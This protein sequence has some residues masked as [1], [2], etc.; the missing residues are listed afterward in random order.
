MLSDP[1]LWRTGA[2][3][4]GAW[5]TETPHG[6]YDLKNPATGELLV[7]LPRCQEAEV[8]GAIE[9]ADRAF[10]E[11]RKV[12]AQARADI[13]RR[14]YDLMLVHKED[15]A[16]LIT[17]EEGKPI[18]EARGEVDY[19]ASFLRWFSEEATRVRGDDNPL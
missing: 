15:L 16:K 12:S 5:V 19:A 4:N 17:L 1:K 3:I 7:S 18:R 11:W 13:I 14:W 10:Q 9:A 6:S 8:D 2:Y